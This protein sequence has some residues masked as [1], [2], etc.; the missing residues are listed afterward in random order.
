MPDYSGK[1][2][3][4]DVEQRESNLQSL[5]RRVAYVEQQIYL[6]QDTLRFNIT[7]GVPYS[8]EEILAVV[9]Q[10]HLEE[11]VDSL[12]RGLDTIISENGKN[13]SGGQRQRIALAR[14][15]IRKVEFIILDEGTSALDDA[16]ALE[17]ETGLVNTPDLGVIIIT[18]NLREAVKEKL[19][20]V[21]LITT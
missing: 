3:Y 12:P 19:T 16:N 17:I 11:Y 20:D 2:Y 5:Y 4:G 14:G 18:H 13:L 8:D 10:C 9:E 6:F 7:L 15:L 21:Y 1:V